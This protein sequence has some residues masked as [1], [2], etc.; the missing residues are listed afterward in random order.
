MSRFTGPLRRVRIAAPCSADWR[1]MIG[2]EQMRFCNQCQQNVYNLS[3]MTRKEAEKLIASAEGRLCVRF[4]RR[5]DGTILTRNCPVGL[6]A[7]STR[8]WRFANATVSTALGFFVGLGLDTALCAKKQP[9]MT[10]AM[11][12]PI[13]TGR[14]ATMDTPPTEVESQT[15]TTG[16]MIITPPRETAR[17]RRKKSDQSK[18]LR[19]QMRRSAASVRQIL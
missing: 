8:L 9:A 13:S 11:T 12:T 14:L 7:L 6:R 1:E 3:G 16:Q 17:V 10:G 2:N 4:Y 5:S 19:Q 15:W 18:R